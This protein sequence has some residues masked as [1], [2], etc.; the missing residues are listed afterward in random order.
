MDEWTWQD[1]AGRVVEARLLRGLSQEQVA[2]AVG[3]DRTAVTKIEAGRRHIS[4]LE[5]VRLA[6]ALDRPLEWFVSPPP[7]VVVS[8]RAERTDQ[9][10]DPAGDLAIEDLARDVQ[11][12][13][14]IKALRARPSAAARFASFAADD[15]HAAA[16]ASHEARRLLGVAESEPLLELGDAA[17]ATGLFVYSLPLGPAAADGSYVS[18]D[19]A[20]VAVING[21]LDA[22]RRRS[23]VAH[24]LGHHLFGDAFSTDWGVATGDHERAI[25][26]FAINLLLPA[27]GAHQHWST[28]PANRTAADLR[29]AAIVLS[30]A[31]RVSWTAALR[32]LRNLGLLDTDEWRLLDSR[33]PTRADYLECNVRV[34]EELVPPQVP[35]GVS[36]AAIRA[37]RQHKL[38]GERVVEMLRGQITLDDLPPRDEIPLDALRGELR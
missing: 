11:V 5:L 28:L 38:S 12:L 3:I 19:G 15:V 13:L 36:A 14:E 26:A 25:D 27:G 34:T 35:T 4:S 2:E 37:Y 18:L 16:A 6:G 30:A 29:R 17:Q 10:A 32:Q 22:G 8:R 7:A 1:V 31:F 21:S 24:E 9:R 20:G 33:S 23:T